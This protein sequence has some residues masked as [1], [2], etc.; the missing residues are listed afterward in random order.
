MQEKIRIQ[1]DDKSAQLVTFSTSK[2]DFE[3]AHRS[4]GLSCLA[5]LLLPEYEAL[6]IVGQ[7]L[8]A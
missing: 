3:L 2:P 4:N 5:V 8:Q 6:E 1:D 7:I